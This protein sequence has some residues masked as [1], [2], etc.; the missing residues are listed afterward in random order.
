[1]GV[2]KV[3]LYACAAAFLLGGLLPGYVFG[4]GVITGLVALGGA[5][6]S[7]A[8]FR[9]AKGFDVQASESQKVQLEQTARRLAEKNGGSVALSAVMHATGL[10]KDAATVR[11]RELV[12]R[13]VFELDFGANGE[14]LFKLTPMDEARA[15]LAALRDHAD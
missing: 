1:M 9:A 11:M 12:G 5:G 10:P 14:M 4:F 15:Q 2:L 6:L 7:Y 8:T 13:G 3:F